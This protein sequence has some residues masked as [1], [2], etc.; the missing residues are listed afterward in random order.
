MKIRPITLIAGILLGCLGCS[1]AREHSSA[2]GRMTF[3]QTKWQSPTC[4]PDS[5]FLRRNPTRCCQLKTPEPKNGYYE[6]TIDGVPKQRIYSLGPLSPER[7]IATPTAFLTMVYERQN[8]VIRSEGFAAR[9]LVFVLRHVYDEVCLPPS[10]VSHLDAKI[11]GKV[12][13]GSNERGG[14]A[15]STNGW[16]RTEAPFVGE[17][18]FFGRETKGKTDEVR[19]YRVLLWLTI[20]DRDGAVRHPPLR[21]GDEWLRLPPMAILAVC[22]QE[23][24]SVLLLT[25]KT[26]RWELT[27]PNNC[28]DR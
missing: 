14:D 7:V 27:A 18:Y 6:A 25:D 16:V 21:M 19:F 28:H 4:S 5:R 20:D 17:G 12:H 9:E 23:A 11:K 26:H 15:P 24:D 1:F 2:F 3:S 10:C 22:I 13:G 8:Q